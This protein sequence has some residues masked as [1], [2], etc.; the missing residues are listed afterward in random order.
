MGT[1]FGIFI[2]QLINW[3]SARM[4]VS[5]AE[6]P[7][8]DSTNTSTTRAPAM[9][10][11]S[12]TS[13]VAATG[14]ST[15]T[16]TAA[17]GRPISSSVRSPSVSLMDSWGAGG[18]PKSNKMSFT[19]KRIGQNAQVPQKL[20]RNDEEE[21]QEFHEAENDED[22]LNSGSNTNDTID[23]NGEEEYEDEDEDNSSS[24]SSR[25]LATGSAS[26]S[27]AQ[28][29][30]STEDQIAANSPTF[31]F[32]EFTNN[33]KEGSPRTFYPNYRGGAQAFENAHVKGQTII[34]LRVKNDEDP[35]YA[36]YFDG[37]S[38][39]FEIK[40]QLTFQSAPRGILYL[41]GEVPGD[42]Q[43]GV[44]TKGLCRGILSILRK[45]SSGMNYSFGKGLDGPEDQKELPH[46]SF[47]VFVGATTLKLTKAG[48]KV[49]NIDDEI[50]ESHEELKSR[51]KNGQQVTIEAGDTL[52]FSVHS[53]YLDVVEWK[54]TNLGALGNID[55]SLFW[56]TMPLH[57]ILYDVP[58]DAGKHHYEGIKRNYF[59]L[60]VTNT[61]YK[62][63]KDEPAV[64]YPEDTK[65][66]GGEK[67]SGQSNS[68]KPDSSNS[69]VNLG[70]V[71]SS[72][73]QSPENNSVKQ[74]DGG[75]MSADS[76][77]SRLNKYA[78][79]R[80]GRENLRKG[81]GAK[82]NSVGLYVSEDGG[83]SVDGDLDVIEEEDDLYSRNSRDTEDD[84]SRTGSLNESPRSGSQNLTTRDL[85]VLAWVEHAGHK[86]KNVSFAVFPAN[87]THFVLQQRENFAKLGDLAKYC[88]AD[89]TKKPR[90]VWEWETLREQLDKA[91]VAAPAMP[92]SSSWIKSKHRLLSAR[93]REDLHVVV[94]SKYLDGSR[95]TIVAESVVLRPVW[96]TKWQEQWALLIQGKNSKVLYLLLFECFSK[97]PVAVLSASRMLDVL[98]I[99]NSST[100]PFADRFPCLEIHTKGRVLILGFPSDMPLS[101]FEKSLSE[102]S[103]HERD[104]SVV[105]DDS[106]ALLTSDMATDSLGLE[107]SRWGPQKRLI[108]NC[109][110][111]FFN[112]DFARRGISP[113]ANG[114]G[115]GRSLNGCF[116]GG[117]SNGSASAHD[118]DDIHDPVAMDNLDWAHISARPYGRLASIES[119][120][121]LGD[122]LINA[123]K[124]LE[125]KWP[126]KP[127]EL[128]S[129]LLRTAL[130]LSETSSIDEEIRFFDQAAQLRE[131]NIYGWSRVMTHEELTCFALNLY[132]A[133][134]LHAKYLVGQPSSLL[135]W[136]SFG[137]RV[138]Y[139]I[140]AGP[141]GQAMVLS[142]AEI[143]H[144]ILRK[145]MSLA[146]TLVSTTYPSSRFTRLLELRT[147]E[148]RL[149]LA[150]NYGTK[151]SASKIVVLNSPSQMDKLLDAAAAHFLKE[152][153]KLDSSKLIVGLPKIVYWYGKDF[154]AN[155]NTTM[156]DFTTK[157]IGLEVIEYCSEEQ[158]ET[159]DRILRH[160]EATFRVRPFKWKALISQSELG[161]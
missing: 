101:S 57:L 115:S 78:A 86:R 46:I 146:R 124:Y 9:Y 5:K 133:L 128:S 147:A 10:M 20:A 22:Y 139:A 85:I 144:C 132:H 62:R 114:A 136:A 50:E 39:R 125:E 64:I 142:L 63:E 143:E 149:N 42:M 90:K 82:V 53:M 26:E 30:S 153:L 155:K 138:S 51:K 145:P 12:G 36:S 25:K 11:S 84:V 87:G 16:H 15:T 28:D 72:M 59:A 54:V 14:S 1:L 154:A 2:M 120:D 103:R 112:N 83:A 159:V 92:V 6:D 48:E 66:P 157:S 141:S 38:R 68:P 52:T 69:V 24:G 44:V 89:M 55:L 81:L 8:D 37:K 151:S 156:R 79:E 60:C 17:R 70:H 118:Q 117:S 67:D 126:L 131:L 3:L 106:E 105:A 71:S 110:K 88:E 91:L 19:E 31:P 41:G 18:V 130:S 137:A 4:T 34:A 40:F 111:L 97:T 98:K 27:I 160:A 121:V 65:I 7:E 148:P 33:L 76:S 102:S 140:G 150:I 94:P 75:D 49:P 80:N 96:E 123:R 45:V 58:E 99:T 93:R 21:N 100:I 74:S 158:R 116:G 77:S 73:S 161:L 108:I 95:F 119:A 29:S 23:D 47:P 13:S 61:W 56:D 104:G 127:W 107:S 43:L 135:G 32:I 35:A 122:D 113:V 152:Q 129:I 109:R 134:R